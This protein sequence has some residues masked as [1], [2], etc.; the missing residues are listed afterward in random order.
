MNECEFCGTKHKAESAV[1]KCRAK[2]ARQEAAL[3][4]KD[5]ERRRRQDNEDKYPQ[6]GFVRATRHAGGAGGTWERIASALTKDYPDRGYA[7]TVWEVLE[8]YASSL[9]WPVHD[10]IKV[11]MLAEKHYLGTYVTIHPL[12]LAGV[13][14]HLYRD[15]V[16]TPEALRLATGF[17]IEERTE[18]EPD[19]DR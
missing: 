1:E 15:G 17:D 12:E 8:M 11:L 3:E 9:N 4:K 14:E 5:K 16:M 18:D 19:I 2:A 6:P 7:Y 13:R 10:E